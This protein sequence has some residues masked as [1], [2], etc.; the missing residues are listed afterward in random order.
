MGARSKPE[1]RETVTDVLEDL[2]GGI[3]MTEVIDRKEGFPDACI[4]SGQCIMP[5]RGVGR[6]IEQARREGAMIALP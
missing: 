1:T 2:A 4:H 5:Q 6:A 3:A